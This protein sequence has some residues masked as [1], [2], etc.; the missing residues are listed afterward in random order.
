P[1]TR[2]RWRA[3]NARAVGTLDRRGADTGADAR[4]LRT[5][6]PCSRGRDLLLR[7]RSADLPGRGP[8]R[9]A[10]QARSRAHRRGGL[11][12]GNTDAA[13]YHQRERGEFLMKLKTFRILAGALVLAC[14]A[15]AGEVR[16]TS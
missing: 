12:L 5:L 1:P 10:R 13:P 4:P 8:G 14:I 2:S 7:L 3:R 11:V 16:N 6:D 9:A 15:L